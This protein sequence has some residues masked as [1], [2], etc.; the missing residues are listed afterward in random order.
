MDCIVHGVAKSQTLL[1]GFRTSLIYPVEVKSC[2]F[3][4]VRRFHPSFKSFIFMIPLL[5]TLSNHD[6]GINVLTH[7]VKGKMMLAIKYCKYSNTSA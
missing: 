4:Y 7:C 3:Q 2:C 1:R 5:L 6:F